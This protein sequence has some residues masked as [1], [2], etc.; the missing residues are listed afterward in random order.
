MPLAMPRTIRQGWG[1]EVVAE[2][3]P[4]LEAKVYDLIQAEGVS[5]DEF[6]AILSRLEGLD[7]DV[8]LIKEEL[9]RTRT[10]LRQ[11][12]AQTRVEFKEDLAQVRAE[13][14]EQQAQMRA[15]FGEQQAQMRAEFREDLGQVRH[16]MNAGF[17]RVNERFD[18]MHHQMAVQTRWLIGSLA[19]I[20]TVVSVLLAIAQFTP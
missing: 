2:F 15:E 18:Q 16:E 13:F 17:D 9:F 6:R 11:E 3:E 14:G 19:L 4:W 1:E 12:Q 7:K 20:G 5:R 10:E 8:S